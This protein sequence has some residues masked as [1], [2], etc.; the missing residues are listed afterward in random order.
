LVVQALVLGMH[1]YAL[2]EEGRNG[3]G[4]SEMRQGSGGNMEIAPG[5]E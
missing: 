5:S 3:N 1:G 4:G 2:W